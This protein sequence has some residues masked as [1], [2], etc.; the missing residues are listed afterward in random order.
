[1]RHQPRRSRTSEIGRL[2]S[3]AVLLLFVAT[4]LGTPAT[5]QAAARPDAPMVLQNVSLTDIV[6]NKRGIC[7]GGFTHVI[8]NSAGPNNTRNYLKAAA[9]CGLKVIFF[10][11]ETV[12]HSTG[13]IYPSRVPYWV[14]IVKDHP[15]FFGYLSVKEPSWNRISATEIRTLYKAFRA[16]D[17]NH[18]VI[19]LFGDIPH[20][21]STANPYS[22][23]MADIVMVDWYP[24]ETSNNGCSRTGSV[25]KTTGP[26]WLKKVRAHINLKTPG[27]DAWLMVQTHKNLAPRCHKKQRPSETK[28]RRQVRDGLN[29]LKAT[30]IA[31]H[32]WQNTTYQVDQRR[33]PYMVR[34]M[35]TI[36]N[37]VHAGTFQ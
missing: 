25:Y 36:A 16:A 19:A 10:F 17:P 29:Y 23:G 4:T 15:A 32:T 1:M 14:N 8:K 30:G 2:I 13:R 26:R 24:V 35:R 7:N 37:Q 27:R 9:K 22:A 11:G 28:L 33:D 3:S 18:P 12:S 5:T 21:G 34:Y 31:F 6:Y 20:F